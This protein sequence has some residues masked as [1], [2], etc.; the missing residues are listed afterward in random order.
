MKA[1]SSLLCDALV[2]DLKD[3]TSAGAFPGVDFPANVAF[4][5]DDHLL[6]TT[7]AGGPVVL[8][9]L[10]PQELIEIASAGVTRGPTDEECATYVLEPCPSLEAIQAG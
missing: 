5:N 10:D 2:E 9:T 7:A 4:V 1:L 8:V 3:K 6:V